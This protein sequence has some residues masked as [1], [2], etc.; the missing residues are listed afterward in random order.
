[1]Q[2]SDRVVVMDEGRKIAEGPPAAVAAEPRVL[3]AYLG[4]AEVG[5]EVA[6]AGGGGT[7]A[8]GEVT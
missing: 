5:T 3:E 6:S 8:G 1:M 7:Q 2:L 4:H